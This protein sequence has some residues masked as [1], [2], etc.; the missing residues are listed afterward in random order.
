[1]QELEL[2][3][4][5][6]F[7]IWWA[8]AWRSFVFA[9]L[10]GSAIAGILAI[11]LVVIGHREWARPWMLDI[12]DVAWIPAFLMGLRLALR[13]KYRT[14]RIALVLLEPPAA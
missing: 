14:F 6:V 8:A 9:S 5:R 7:R 13:A 11:S 4:G 10:F 2:T 12:V 1:M 3:W